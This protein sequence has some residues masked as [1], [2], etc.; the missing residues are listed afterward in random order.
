MRPYPLVM[1]PIYKPKVWGGRRLETLG[2]TLPEDAA[3]GESWEVAD[4]SATAPE[5]GGGGEARSIIAN[6]EMM[7][8][9]L[10]QAVRAMGLNLLGDMRLT[11]E[12][13]FPL[14]AKYLD[15]RENLSVQVHPSPAY[16]RKHHGAKLKTETWYVVDAAPDAAIYRGFREGVTK[17]DVERAVRSGDGSSLQ[18]LLRRVPVRAGDVHH[19][20]SGTCH[21]L[22]AGVMVAE[23]QTPSDTTFRL[24]D[25]GRT[26]RTVNIDEA[27]ECVDMDERGDAVRG[28]GHGRSVVAHTEFY[29][30][31][32]WFLPDGT[33]HAVEPTALRPMVWMVLNGEGIITFDTTNGVR[34]APIRIH[35]GK[36]VVIPAMLKGARVAWERDAHVLEVA[37]PGT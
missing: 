26:N 9:T 1:E 6:G 34:Q 18:P 13:A 25:W 11:E 28:P 3:I 23:I 2:R 12:G 19:L 8:L 29:D 17:K 35:R 20:P 37:F 16:A 21:A 24:W 27:L 30:L 4:L 14:L 36:T 32:E 10:G 15:A 31:I 33:E 22:G 7:G 5:G